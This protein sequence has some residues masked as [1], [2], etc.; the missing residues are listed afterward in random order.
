MTA[1]LHLG[2]ARPP[3]HRARLAWPEEPRPGG[4]R[5]RRA[6]QQVPQIDR[7]IRIEEPDG[8]LSGAF[9]LRCLPGWEGLNG[10]RLGRLWDLSLLAGRPGPVIEFSDLRMRPDAALAEVL[11][12][13][14]GAVL[15][16]AERG[17]ATSILG[18]CA[19]PGLDPA[20]H[21]QALALLRADHVAPAEWLPRAVAAGAVPLESLGR[22]PDRIAAVRGLPPLLRSWLGLGA[23]VADHAVPDPT[24]GNLELCVILDPARIPP[25]R[26][27]ALRMAPPLA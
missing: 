19:F 16:A 15:A 1:S 22:R 25:L 23:W 10:S 4:W 11:R 24:T 12:A 21:R 18:T 9:R 27:Q 2:E 7:E 14:W 3:L 26:V 17:G 20:P 8:A 6:A 5:R 13:A